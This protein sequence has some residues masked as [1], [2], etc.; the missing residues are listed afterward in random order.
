MAQ[1]IVGE[2]L[3]S[4]IRAIARQQKRPEAELL[5]DLVERYE[6][7]GDPRHLPPRPAESLTDADIETPPDITDP[8]QVEEYRAAARSL[9][10][11]LY[12]IARRYWLKIG[13]TERLALTDEELD[14]VFWLIDHEGIPRFKS[15]KDSVHLPPDPLEKLV[16]IINSD[17]TD[18]S[19]T[20]RE[21]LAAYYEKKYGRS[22]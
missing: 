7:K 15:E 18:L 1:L 14:K 9:R 8:K 22:S 3:A 2:P 4:R 21:S 19:T 10:P 13:D 6:P 16:G 11:K 20:V 5:A 17:Q 12:R